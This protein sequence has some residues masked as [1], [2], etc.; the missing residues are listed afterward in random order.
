MKKMTRESEALIARLKAFWTISMKLE[1]KVPEWPC[2]PKIKC[3]YRKGV[4]NPLVPMMEVLPHLHF[5]EDSILDYFQEGSEWGAAPVLYVRKKDAPRIPDRVFSWADS[6]DIDIIPALQAVE[7]EFSSEGA[8]EMV[9]LAELG[10]QFGLFWH[11][12]YD[13]LRIIYDLDEF[14][15]GRYVGKRDCD[16]CRKLALSNEDWKEIASWNITPKVN[17][18]EDRAIVHYCVFSPF[19]GFFMVRRTL[20]FRPILKLMPPVRVKKIEYSC[21]IRY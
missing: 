21:G 15:G 16:E 6:S 9:L 5:P 13:M 10:T 3:N 4:E 19:G 17:M 2:L 8:W 18:K 12:C 11:A 7:P 20:L 1:S 14:R